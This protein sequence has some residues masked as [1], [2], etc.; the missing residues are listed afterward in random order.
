MVYL[1]KMK[2]KLFIHSKKTVN[3]S[4]FPIYRYYLF[5]QYLRKILYTNSKE[6]LKIHM[7]LLGC[8]KIM[9]YKTYET[10]DN[11][12][13]EESYHSHRTAEITLS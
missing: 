3:L 9:K 4:I 10:Y 7:N 8:G 13:F 12:I 11:G 5:D 1:K 2:Y 6:E